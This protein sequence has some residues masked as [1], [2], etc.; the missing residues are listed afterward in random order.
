MAADLAQ[1]TALVAGGKKLAARIK[2]QLKEFGIEARLCQSVAEAR[3]MAE[4]EYFD[5]IFL[6]SNLADEEDQVH[7][8]E[9]LSAF[10]EML[11]LVLAPKPDLAQ[12]V[13]AIR[14]GAFDYLSEKCSAKE[15]GAAIEGALEFRAL[16][17]ENID[18][19][20]ELTRKYD[21]ENII[22]NSAPMQKVFRLIHKVGD[23]DA[24]VLVLG[25]SGTGK[26]LVARAIHYN[27]PRRDMPLVPVNC[28]AIPEELL[29]S[30]LF[31]HEKGAFTGAIRTR[32]GR[33]EMAQGGTIFLDEIGDMSP[34]L[35]V[36]LLRVLQEH[37]FERIGSTTTIDADIRVIAATHQNLEKR[38]EE[39]KFREDL[40]YRINVVP[41]HVPPL[42]DRRSDIGLL[43]EH[44]LG[45]TAKQRDDPPKKI[46][47]E[48][49]DRLLRHPWPGNVRE[50]EN[51]LE[52]MVILS[53]GNTVVI[54]DLPAKVRGATK[55]N[56]LLPGAEVLLHTVEMPDDG[57]DFKAEVDAFERRLI[58]QA[59]EQSGWVKNRA[60]ALLKLNRTTLVEKI[61]KK[62]LVQAVQPGNT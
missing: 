37:Q 59:L 13:E 8:A 2:N 26:E 23:S 12:G 30:E 17:N 38:V 34:M 29:E 60:A 18:R 48:V 53:E 62:G 22:G 7:A 24:T 51:V 45:R 50:L 46:H 21:V 20:R 43:C 25:E 15:I 11:L 61:K 56:S 16:R 14:L 10:P 54:E 32:L 19:R 4:Q 6:H 55:S 5:L 49:M 31:G 57:L 41:I 33:F 47:P 9:M 27:S 44:L 3:R 40:Y 39:G 58:L 42:R 28:G 35:Q 52:R 36:K 1:T